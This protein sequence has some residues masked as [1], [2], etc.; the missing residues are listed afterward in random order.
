MSKY[1]DAD[2]IRSFL[3]PDEWKTPDERWRPESEFGAIVEA[4]SP[5]DVEPVRHGHWIKYDRYAV[6]SDGEPVLKIGEEYEC[7]LCGRIEG[8]KEP[9][10]HCGAKM[11]G[12][13]SDDL[14]HF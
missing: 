8:K 1:I 11:D 5:A 2:K 12:R 7:S 4:I 10:C 13:A 9:Y 3:R 6:D 14:Q